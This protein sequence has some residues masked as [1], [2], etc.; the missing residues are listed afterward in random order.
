MFLTIIIF[1]IVLSVLVFAH[2][3]GHFMMARKFGVK[4]EEFG[5]GFPPRAFGL[6]VWRER[7]L[8][9]VSE[10][11]AVAVK[12]EDA[13]PM[14]GATIIKETIIDEK[15]E[16]DILG[17]V[18]KFNFIK[19][20]REISPAEQRYGTVYSIN[21]LPLGGF[22]KIKGENGEGENEADSFASRPIWQRALMLSAGVVMNV[23]LAMILIIVGFM[24]GLPQSLDGS[25]LDARAQVSDRKIQIVQVVKGSPAE[26]AALIIGDTIISIDNTQFSDFSELQNYVN[27]KIGQQ[28]DYK[29]KRGQELIDVKI[30]PIMMSET[31]RGGIGVALSETGIVSY[32]WYLA[33]L[34]GVKA[35]FILVWVIIAA[36][37]ELLK[38]LIMGQGVSADLAGPVG[39]ATL[40]GEVARMGF[41]YLMQFT[42]LLSINLAVINF[43]PF[44]ALDGGRV[45]FLIIEKIKR[46]PVKREVEAVIH[47][48]GFILLMVLVVLVTFR[49]VARFGGVFKGIWEKIF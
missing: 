32:P 4:A 21:W 13:S 30:A 48:V 2:E 16:I 12:L 28:L 37:Y 3:L 42:A 5:L 33:I 22:V 45:L 17:W 8:E 29:I 41:V 43:L 40:T 14:G 20:S 23:A 19:G 1:I 27:N 44:P 31:G 11:E 39:I 46:K 38:S 35:T 7:K 34:E 9:K 36:F 10:E 6:Q 24:V 18:R 49:D 47:N 15:R 26:S 25:S